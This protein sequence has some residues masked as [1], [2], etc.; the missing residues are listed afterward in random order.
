M[1]FSQHIYNNVAIFLLMFC[2]PFHVGC[3]C[4][5]RHENVLR[6]LILCGTLCL[7]ICQ[8]FWRM[9]AVKGKGA[10]MHRTSGDPKRDHSTYLW[11]HPGVVLSFLPSPH[12]QPFQG[13]PFNKITR[14][15]GKHLDSGKVVMLHIGSWLCLKY[16]S[17]SA[18]ILLE[19]VGPLDTGCV[20][21]RRSFICSAGGMVVSCYPYGVLVTGIYDKSSF[22]FRLSSPLQIGLPV[23]KIP[24]HFH[25]HP[26]CNK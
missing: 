15:N 9:L 14:T 20:K 2:M 5:T 12:P 8:K 1:Y 26:H 4:P 22:M 21:P 6:E 13:R 10:H 24:D 16:G 17:I 23:I 25:L 7:D 11:V 18:L 19:Y 3:W